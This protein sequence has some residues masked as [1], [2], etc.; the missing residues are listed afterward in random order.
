[1]GVSEDETPPYNPTEIA[2]ALR[3]SQRRE[4]RRYVTEHLNEYN[5]LLTPPGSGI[6]REHVQL[7]HST[8]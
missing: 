1:M 5:I 2:A 3:A 6:I 8:F 7:N 4:E